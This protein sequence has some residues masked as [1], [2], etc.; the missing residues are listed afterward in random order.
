[1]HGHADIHFF[2]DKAAGELLTRFNTP[3]IIKGD[4]ED[5]IVPKSHFWVAKS[6]IWLSQQVKKPLLRLAYDDY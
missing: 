1:M 5:P 3:W 2:I 4:I 6:V